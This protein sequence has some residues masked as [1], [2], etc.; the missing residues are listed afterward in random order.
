MR[1]EFPLLQSCLGSLGTWLTDTVISRSGTSEPD[2][3][4]ESCGVPVNQYFWLNTLHPTYP[5][6]DV[7]A[8]QVAKALEAGPNVCAQVRRR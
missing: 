3:L 2:T 5:V 7:V 6:H 8:E 4:D 1:S